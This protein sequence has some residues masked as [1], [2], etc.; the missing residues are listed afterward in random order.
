M[1]CVVRRKP[2]SKSSKHYRVHILCLQTKHKR[3]PKPVAARPQAERGEGAESR[4]SQQRSNAA[5]P[6]FCFIVCAIC[7]LPS[8]CFILMPHLTMAV[9]P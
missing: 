9:I 5:L 7:S 2:A 4:F 1:H 8:L 3:V 6:W